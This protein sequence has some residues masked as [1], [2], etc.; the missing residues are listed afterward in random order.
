[1]SLEIGGSWSTWREPMQS[2]GEHANSTQKDP[3]PGDRTQGLRI[4]RHMHQTLYHCVACERNTDFQNWDRSKTFGQDRLSLDNTYCKLDPVQGK[5]GS[6]FFWT[7]GLWRSGLVSK[8]G[9]R[10][11]PELDLGADMV[12]VPG[13]IWPQRHQLNGSALEIY[14]LRQ[15][16]FSKECVHS[17][18]CTEIVAVGQE[19]HRIFQLKQPHFTAITVRMWLQPQLTNILI[20]P[21][22]PVLQL[23]LVHHLLHQI[24]YLV[25]TNALL[26]VQKWTNHLCISWR[27]LCAANLS[28]LKMISRW[29]HYGLDSHTIN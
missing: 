1:M 3:E 18:C 27:R 16:A 13:Q 12:S 20:R 5:C 14:C 21:L 17:R 29:P 6:V 23:G 26:A 15:T 4:V 8:S 10:E 25:T 19:P 7:S 28:P 9:S 22:E 24:S 2:Q 11:T